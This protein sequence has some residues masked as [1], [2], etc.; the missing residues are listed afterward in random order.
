MEKSKK[1]E[2]LLAKL[3]SPLPI[4]FICESILKMEMFDCID[5][6]DELVKDG[7]LEEENKIYKLKQK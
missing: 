1:I 6:L 2:L 7:I 4:S 5:L 3:R